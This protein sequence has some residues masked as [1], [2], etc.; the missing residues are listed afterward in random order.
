MKKSRELHSIFTPSVFEARHI[1][2]N[3]FILTITIK[4][5]LFCSLVGIQFSSPLIRMFPLSWKTIELPFSYY[6]V[7]WMYFTKLHRLQTFPNLS[8]GWQIRPERS[9]PA[10]AVSY[11]WDY[12]YK[13]RRINSLI[14]RATDPNLSLAWECRPKDQVCRRSRAVE[15]LVSRCRL[16]EPGWK[17]SKRA[18]EDLSASQE[19][20][21]DHLNPEIIS[22]QISFQSRDLSPNIIWTQRTFRIIIIFGYTFWLHHHMTDVVIHCITLIVFDVLI[23]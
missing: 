3:L 13:K 15:F 12:F 20:S 10:T 5:V 1:W 18:S 7:C 17:G 9:F 8:D 21:R 6:N 4:C 14:R 23:F 22:I 11:A 19:H 2:G 16:F